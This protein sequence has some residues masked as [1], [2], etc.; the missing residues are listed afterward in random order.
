MPLNWIMG[1][2]MLNTILSFL[3]CGFFGTCE[4][5]V[6]VQKPQFGPQ[7]VHENGLLVIPPLGYDAEKIEM[8]FRL[9][10]H[11]KLRTPMQMEI[12]LVTDPASAGFS[13]TSEKEGGSGGPTFVYRNSKQAGKCW[14]A[15]VADKQDEYGEPLFID[16]VDVLAKARLAMP[17][18]IC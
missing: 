5:E 6:P 17:S 1:A 7:L 13:G 3:L 16:A 8:G 10:E 9:T 11:G 14:I 2:N 15:I 4:S 18:S 12:L